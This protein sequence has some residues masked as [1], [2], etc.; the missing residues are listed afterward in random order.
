M[1]G[2]DPARRSPPTQPP[3]A[4]LVGG[5]GI[6]FT[7]SG[8]NCVA[9]KPEEDKLRVSLQLAAGG[10]GI[11]YQSFAVS[12]R[13]VSIKLSSETENFTAIVCIGL[14][15][16]AS[17]DRTADRPVVFVEAALNQKKAF[18]SQLWNAKIRRGY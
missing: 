4:G 11:L 14:V 6:G 5:G 16:T 17:H 10:D 18:R 2:V 15:R 12:G 1:V 8:V 3:V 9:L 7:C 13:I